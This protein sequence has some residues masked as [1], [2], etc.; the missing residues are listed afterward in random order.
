MMIIIA[1]GFGSDAA[2]RREGTMTDRSD[3]E[4]TRPN[5]ANEIALERAELLRVLSPEQLARL[6][7]QL[8]ERPVQPHR[9]LFFEGGE[10]E[11][12]WIL[13]R[14]QVRLYK[15]SA[16]GRVTTLETLGPGEIFGAIS[17]LEGEVYPASAEGVLAGSAWCLPRST[18]MQLL[19]SDPR[20]GVEVLRIVSSRLHQAHQ[21]LHA[22]AQDSAPARL[23]RAL[24]DAAQGGEARVTRRALAESA[25]TTVETAIRVLR[26]FEREG[27]LHGQ[28]GLLRLLDAEALRRVA[29]G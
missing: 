4:R 10:A 9:A 28:V 22:F 17:A 12:L 25:G 15:A 5:A 2:R 21:R 11:G 27:L 16:S 19:A 26:R 1:I 24:L 8:R 14:G 20:L 13:R 23:A 29:G 3:A 18:L 6:R 7:P